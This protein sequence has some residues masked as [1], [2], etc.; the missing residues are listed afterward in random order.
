MDISGQHKRK[1][2]RQ[3][4]K[5][6]TALHW[7][8]PT[9]LI[10]SFGKIM[11][12]D[13][14]NDSVYFL[15]TASGAATVINTGMGW[16]GSGCT[17]YDGV[18]CV[19]DRITF[20]AVAGWVD[21]AGLYGVALASIDMNHPETR[22]QYLVNL[23]MCGENLSTDW[24]QPSLLAINNAG[25][26]AF[27]IYSARD[28][29]YLRDIKVWVPMGFNFHNFTWA[30]NNLNWA[31]AITR[32]PTVYPYV[33]D[34][35]NQRMIRIGFGKQGSYHP[36][37]FIGDINTPVKKSS[38][39]MVPSNTDQPSQMVNI[40]GQVVRRDGLPG[41]ASRQTLRPGVYLV[42]SGKSNTATIKSI[43][44]GASN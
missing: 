18:A 37:L 6:I 5:N 7:S 1:I 16:A 38:I 8:S 2:T 40:R 26:D 11:C 41:I 23:G 32:Q 15:D 9:K 36:D 4:L 17:G 12:P 42:Q 24:P 28:G 44:G 34:A 25:H 33:I 10:V 19:G 39:R 14:T 43:I 29:S 13:C 3:P 27:K 35:V 21:N 22:I 31:I 20:R 30:R